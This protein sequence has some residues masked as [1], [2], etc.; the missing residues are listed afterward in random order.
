[1][2]LGSD[3]GRVIKITIGMTIAAINTIPLMIIASFWDL[4]NPLF[5][6]SSHMGKLTYSGVSVNGF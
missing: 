2:K 3:V 6:D 4:V 5:T 1:M